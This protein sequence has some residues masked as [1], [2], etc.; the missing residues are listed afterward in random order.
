MYDPLYMQYSRA[1]EGW[2]DEPFEYCFSFSKDF[3]AAIATASAANFQSPL[4]FDPDADFYVRSM[5]IAIF[6]L[7]IGLEAG[8][9]IITLAMRLRD[10]F[11]RPL[12]NDFI[13]MSAYAM[14]PTQNNAF[15]ISATFPQLVGTPVLPELYCPANGFMFAEFQGLIAHQMFNFSIYL[16]G[17]KR[18]QNEDCK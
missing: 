1:P 13:V 2:H 10:C 3:G 16:A 18:F 12:D 9:P 8:D 5:A 6:S 17:V 14:P 7:P 11:G 4:Q 15:Q